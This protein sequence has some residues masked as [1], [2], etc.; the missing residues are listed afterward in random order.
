LIARRENI[1]PDIISGDAVD[2]FLPQAGLL[3]QPAINY[4]PQN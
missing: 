2:G 3:K 4:G 1:R